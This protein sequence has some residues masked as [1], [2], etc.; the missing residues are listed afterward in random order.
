M[1]QQEG[2]NPKIST[3]Y[4][5]KAFMIYMHDLALLI[6]LFYIH[7]QYSWMTKNSGVGTNEHLNSKFLK[8]I[9][10][11]N[12]G[13]D[14]IIIHCWFSTCTET[15]SETSKEI[16]WHLNMYRHVPTFTG[17]VSKYSCFSLLILSSLLSLPC[18]I[19]VKMCI[20]NDCGVV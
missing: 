16:F 1:D 17:L 2:G 10:L 12:I 20:R 14:S 6:V 4:T 7:I 19:Q 13:I 3:T 15:V 5:N 11:S 18:L 9:F 8:K